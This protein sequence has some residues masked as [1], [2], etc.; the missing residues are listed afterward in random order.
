MFKAVCKL[1]L[2]GIVSKKL[3]A[4]VTGT[5]SFHWSLGGLRDHC[6]MRMAIWIVGIFGAGDFTGFVALHNG[7]AEHRV[8]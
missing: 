3:D 2:E 1:G 5:Q 8:G 6:R 4:F 7:R